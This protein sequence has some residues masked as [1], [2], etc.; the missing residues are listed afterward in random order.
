M[1]WVS[2]DARPQHPQLPDEDAAE[3]A[4]ADE[5]TAPASSTLQ[6]VAVGSLAVGDRVRVTWSERE[7]HDGS[8]VDTR[9]ELA[10]NRG[11]AT[12]SYAQINYDD[13]DLAWV[14]EGWEVRRI[15]WLVEAPAVAASAEEVVPEVAA[16]VEVVQEEEEEE[17]EEEVERIHEVERIVEYRMRRGTD[18]F[19]VRWLG[20][21]ASHDTWEPYENLGASVKRMATKMKKKKAATPMTEA[22]PATKAAS[23]KR[24]KATGSAAVP[25]PG[26][27]TASSAAAS[28]MALVATENAHERECGICNEPLSLNYITA[29]QPCGHAQY[30]RGCLDQWTI[31]KRCR[32]CPECRVKI[33]S[34]GR[35][36]L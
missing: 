17:E 2:V 30:C 8:V 9:S 16:S 12:V 24:K 18:E 3:E 1:G 6:V 27:A 13:G 5:A 23:R 21:S 4:L 14:D 11:I 25:A 7:T 10:S 32:T 26:S 29:I 15:G 31:V 22:A 33:R 20:H 28:S 34:Y 19:K 36:F 35:I